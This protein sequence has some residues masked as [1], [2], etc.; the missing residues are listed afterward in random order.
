MKSNF[1]RMMKL[2]EDVFAVKN[3]PE[4]LDVNEDVIEQLMG[5]VRKL[6][7]KC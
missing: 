5:Q 1:E 4:Q 3:D 2:A 7:I 6:G